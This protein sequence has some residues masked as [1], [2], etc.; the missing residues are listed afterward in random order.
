M[1][2]RLPTGTVSGVSRHNRKVSGSPV[3]PVV[4]GP[5]RDTAS[6]MSRDVINTGQT[7]FPD[8][9][10]HLMPCRNLLTMQFI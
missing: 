1:L 8:A 10:R 9:T 2:L 5:D 7:V 6:H 4:V 3:L